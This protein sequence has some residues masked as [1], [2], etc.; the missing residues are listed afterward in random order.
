MATKARRVLI[1]V[2]T[3]EASRYAVSWSLDHILRKDDHIV[4]VSICWVPHLFSVGYFGFP[5]WWAETMEEVRTNAEKFLSELRVMALEKGFTINTE[6][7]SGD[8][9]EEIIQYA[10]DVDAEFIIVGAHGQSHEGVLED[11]HGKTT[12]T[13]LKKLTTGS[14]SNHI[15]QHASVPVMVVRKVYKETPEI[16][17]ADLLA[18][19]N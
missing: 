1:A 3:S 13:V 19:A 2:D 11:E 7:K 12:T 9:R 16:Q 4:V 6:T 10:E 15:M 14:I 5:K 17:G 18:P 8:P